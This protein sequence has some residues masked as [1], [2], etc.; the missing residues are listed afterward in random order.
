MALLPLFKVDD[1]QLTLW[2]TKWKALLDVL[3]SSRITNGVFIQNITTTAGANTI[4]H[5]LGR[6]QLGWFLTD[7]QGIATVYRSQPFNATSLT[8]TVS[9][10]VTLSIWVF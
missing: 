4:P 2:Q 8:L 9:T 7:I 6:M 10:P 3:L 5:L 1:V